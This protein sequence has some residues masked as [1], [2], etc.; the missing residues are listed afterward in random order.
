MDKL[1]NQTEMELDEFSARISTT[2]RTAETVE[3]YKKLSNA[4]QDDIKDIG[5][6]V[7]GT[8]KGGRRKK[9]CVLTRSGLCL[10]MDYA[11]KSKSSQFQGWVII[12]LSSKRDF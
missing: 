1:W 6:F 7:L 5:G 11:Q 10:D 9:E 2:H 8:L 12:P 3:Q 4:K